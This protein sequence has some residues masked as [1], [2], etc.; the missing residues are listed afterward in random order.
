MQNERGSSSPSTV[1]RRPSPF[2]AAFTCSIPVLLG[3]LAIGTGFGL[4]L[5]SKG[6]PVWFAP[7]M[8]LVMFAGAAQYI[9]VGLFASGASLFEMLLVTLVVNARHL[10]YGFSLISRYR[11][12]PWYRW[13]LVFAMTDETFALV[14]SIAPGDERLKEGGG[15]FLFWLSLLDQ[16]YWVAGTLLGALAG[17]ILPWNLEGIEFA[18]TALFIVLMIEQIL[19]VKRPTPFVLTA[20]VSFLA[21]FLVP[22]K[23]VLLSSIAASLAAL[24]LVE[25]S[26]K[27][28][29]GRGGAQSAASEGGKPC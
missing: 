23:A 16:S 15:P 3:Y 17:S 14:S 2:W 18:L 4:L 7:L 9:A 22:G 10:A 6:Y 28:P 27:P 20:L 29:A 25:A 26:R 12:L 5:V 21:V 19:R 11:G 13:Y 8:S 1:S 24:A